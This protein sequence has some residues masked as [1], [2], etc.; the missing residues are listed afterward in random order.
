MRWSIVRLIW[1]REL[2]DQLRDRRTLFMI[3]GLPILLY[4][5]A[6]VGML[7]MALVLGTKPTTVGVIGAEN[8]PGPSPRVPSQSPFPISAWFSY[9]PAS[10][11]S[12]LAGVVEAWS[13]ATFARAGH[14][15][16]Q[17]EFPPLFMPALPEKSDL[18]SAGRP[19]G[20]SRSPE[21]GALRISSLYLDANSESDRF[22]IKRLIG[23]TAL[24]PLGAGADTAAY[25]E[26][27]DRASLE[28]KEVDLIL[29]VPPNFSR[30]LEE[31][32]R[33]PIFL[34]TREG[35]ERSRSAQNRFN[36]ILN[37]WKKHLKQV[38]LIR[39][40]LPSEFD[41]P[42]EVF[43]R[44]NAKPP[45]R[46]AAEELFDLLVRIF[47]FVL[48]MWSLAGALYPA[49]DVCA[50][51]K[52]R[53][54]ME[55]LLI[56]PASREEIVWGKFLTIWVFSAVT[57]LLNLVSMGLTTLH[58]SRVFDPG[59][60]R[61]SVLGWGV[62]L[63]L[64][65]SA[66]FSAL[67]LAVGVYARSSKE[68]QYYLMPLFLLTM[69]LIFLTL[70]PGV[71]LNP[72]YSMIPVTGVALLL[73]KL[74]AAGTPSLEHGVYVFVVLV[75]LA[76]YCWLALRWA[77]EQFNREEVLFR[78]AER[79]DFRLWFGHLFRDKELLPSTG[80][81]M[82]CFGLIL[83]LRWLSLGLGGAISFLP[84]EA[85]S[86]VAFV[87]APPL[88][89]TLML[90][91]WPRQGIG[92]R[93][94]AKWSWPLSILLGL[95]VALPLA[96]ITMLVFDQLPSIK[97]WVKESGPLASKMLGLDET[98][99]STVD[100]LWYFL[101]LAVL[102][103]VCEELAFRGFI[104][105][106]LTRRFRPN[107]A[108]FISALLYALYPMNLIELPTKFLLGS[109]LAFLVMRA[110]SIWPAILAH[111]TFNSILYGVLLFPGF[112][113]LLPVALAQTNALALESSLV[114]V[115]GIIL[116]AASGLAAIG[117]LVLIW[118]LSRGERAPFPK[119]HFPPKA[120]SRVEPA[121]GVGPF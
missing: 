109:A 112:D 55:T 19:P 93:M 62:L 24:P 78:E 96:E 6:A 54:T 95:A 86:Q 68:G 30:L 1:S 97:N 71:E 101:I 103:A 47:P 20:T 27:I 85:I 3:V 84:R 92:V 64:P 69:P 117:L 59:S 100:R 34:L 42:F 79:L 83:A 89:M 28:S 51:E 56:S 116:A 14:F 37:R 104:L 67:C 11:G 72:F 82:C 114:D 113:R 29:V 4:P 21:A 5:I 74:M 50:G 65:L 7:Q 53:G 39:V 118:A 26:R 61:L 120:D 49:V 77:I 115:V 106:G 107:T 102:P 81:A 40:N 32:G 13:A 45:R 2:R 43:D 75:P 33:P 58:F 35:D 38:R 105:T 46:R 17:Q 16:P 36:N 44:D 15:D 48:V 70:A 98:D 66:F 87:A 108:L 121:N 88:F 99:L 9:T 25:L 8:L 52:E 10:P 90:T 119:I 94:P 12:P 73:Q 80:E 76:A 41:E 110:N 57:A 23:G 60:F 22:Q 91:S 111:L 18:A 63:L 31:G